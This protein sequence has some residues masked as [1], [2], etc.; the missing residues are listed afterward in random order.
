MKSF[1]I[2]EI[3]RVNVSEV[4]Q[5]A[6]FPTTTTALVNVK[7]GDEIRQRVISLAAIYKATPSEKEKYNG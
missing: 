4:G 3:V 7:D 1:T 2:G 5:I 6:A